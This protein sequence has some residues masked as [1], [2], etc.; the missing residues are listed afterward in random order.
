MR[1]LAQRAK[2]EERKRLEAEEARRKA[3]EQAEKKKKEE[4]IARLK[5]H[6]PSVFSKNVKDWEYLY[7]DFYYTWLFYYYPTTCDFDANEEEWD[8]RYMVW[9]FKNDPE[10]HISSQ[11][12]EN[13][14]E[15]II[16]QI[17]QK[18]TYTFGEEYLQF[19][20]LFCLPA[21]M[22]QNTSRF[23]KCHAE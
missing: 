4:Q 7:A 17:K 21:S 3:E 14:L 5:V 10:K 2:E 6:A 9:N 19:L 1:I 22:A 13:I 8:N 18:L 23:E 15:E 20:T 11:D 16:P 12:H